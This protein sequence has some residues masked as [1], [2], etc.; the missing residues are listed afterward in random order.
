MS[1]WIYIGLF[2]LGGIAAMI[3]VMAGGGS[4]LTIPFLIF[5]GLDSATANGTARIA[6]VVQNATSTMAFRRKKVKDLR[7]SLIYAAFTLPG[8]LLGALTAIKIDHDWFMKILA[9]VM[10]GITFT[11]FIPK[12]SVQKLT[13]EEYQRRQKWVYL[14][15]LATGF[16]GGFIQIGVG[17]LFI[18]LFYNVLHMDM[19]VVNMHKV[20]IV[21]CY[22]IPSMVLFVY[23]G[24]VDWLLGAVLAAGNFTGAWI[25]TNLAIQQGEKLIKRVLACAIMLIVLKLLNVF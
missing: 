14:G 24:K 22:I 21:M 15:L 4:S 6:L 11:L 2:F 18:G 8:A 3:N 10:V 13:V 16:Y 19:V 25:G 7:N 23:Y 17:F 9:V 1:E 12:P 20:F 5:M